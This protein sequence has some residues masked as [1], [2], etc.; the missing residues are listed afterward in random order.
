[1]G[2]TFKAAQ[3]N[4]FVREILL[5]AEYLVPDDCYVAMGCPVQTVWN[6]LDCKDPQHGINDYDLI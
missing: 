5:R 6:V 4:S 2:T 1:M 3:Q